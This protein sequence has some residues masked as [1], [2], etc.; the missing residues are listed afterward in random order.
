[1][2]FI[3]KYLVG[4][5]FFFFLLLFFSRAQPFPLRFERELEALRREIA[6]SAARTSGSDSSN[7]LSRAGSQNDLPSLL[8]SSS[9]NLPNGYGKASPKEA[10]KDL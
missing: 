10:K 2:A 6:E 4:S 5:E 7:N 1:M 9:Q 8:R 3:S